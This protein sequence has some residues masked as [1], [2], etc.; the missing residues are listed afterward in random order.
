MAT[1]LNCLGSGGGHVVSL[2]AFYSDDPSSNLAEVY[3]FYSVNCLKRTKINKKR[4]GMDQFFKKRLNYHRYSAYPFG[5]FKS[6][7]IHHDDTCIPE[8]LGLPN[9]L[10]RQVNRIRT[11]V[12]IYLPRQFKFKSARAGSSL[13]SKQVWRQSDYVFN[14]FCCLYLMKR[15]FLNKNTVAQVRSWDMELVVQYL[16]TPIGRDLFGLKFFIIPTWQRPEIP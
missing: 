3:S 11:H 14:V 1:R 6:L 15:P 8:N 10:K 9:F 4:P 5:L 13:V 2:L 16:S 12:V 7:I